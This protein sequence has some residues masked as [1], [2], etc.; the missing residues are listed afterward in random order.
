MAV[1]I[2]AFQIPAEMYW[3][4][5]KKRKGRQKARHYKKLNRLTERCFKIGLHKAN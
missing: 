1:F 3:R 4:W 2:D 5:M